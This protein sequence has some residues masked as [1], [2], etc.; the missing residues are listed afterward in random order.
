MRPLLRLPGKISRTPG[1]TTG[2]S[3]AA[4]V[5]QASGAMLPPTVG[6][7]ETWGA[8]VSPVKVTRPCYLRL[9]GPGARTLRVLLPGIAAVQ[10]DQRSLWA[11][12]A[13][14]VHQLAKRRASRGGQRVSGVAQVVEMG[15]RH[16]R[17]GQLN[18]RISANALAVIAEEICM[19]RLGLVSLEVASGSARCLYMEVRMARRNISWHAEG[20]VGW[21]RPSFGKHVPLDVSLVAASTPLTSV[22]H[23][24]AK[25]TVPHH[26]KLTIVTV[27]ISPHGA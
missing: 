24:G 7:D 18:R 17:P 23:K 6:R 16:S 5:D 2:S 19:R 13:H 22:T 20:T 14:P 4:S 25:P 12:M 11:A 8:A 10:V 9:P 15:A 21:A 1:R 3:P 27:Q 26:G